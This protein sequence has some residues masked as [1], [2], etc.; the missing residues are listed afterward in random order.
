MNISDLT[1]IVA[2]GGKSSRMGRDKRFLPMD[3]E[4]LLARTLR[5]SRAA[6]FRA[7]VLAAEGVRSDLSA[8]AEEFGATLVTDE[9][10]AQ[11]PAAAIAAGLAA[12][13]T[14]WSLVLSGDMPFYDFELVRA[15]LSAA[16]GDTQ[17][18]LPTL[19]G[20][21]QPLAALY[22]RDAGAVFA[23]AIARGDRKLGIILRE[24]AVQELALTVDAGLF[25]N[26]NTPA[27]YR[28]ALGRLANEQRRRPILSVAAPASGTGKTT[29]IERL[30]P[31]LRER[32]VAVAVIKSDSHGFDLDTEGKDSARFSAAG[33]EAVAVS[34]PHGYFILQKT[35][36][37]KDFQNLIAKIDSNSVNLYITESRS[38]GVLPTLML[39]RG[40]GTPEIDERV[41]AHF[42]KDPARAADVL[43]ADLDDMDTAV[44]LAL[45]L[46]GRPLYGADGAMFLTM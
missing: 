44:R 42:V 16:E 18:V 14:E 43:T 13:E 25:F 32:G 40:V 28:L 21:W 30:I 36:S 15:L 17:V 46:M 34:S 11:G 26:V 22:R 20:Y 12:A 19:S 39:D 4:P 33:A 2:A 9:Q 6:G 37:R 31:L 7:I 5:K 29:F 8:L 1:L 3:G 27:A 24:L 45:F 38:H 23:A 35:K 41:V 10:P